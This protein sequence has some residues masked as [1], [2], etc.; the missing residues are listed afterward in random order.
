MIVIFL[1]RSGRTI[2]AVTATLARS[3]APVVTLSPSTSMSGV[4]LTVSPTSPST[5]FMTTTSPTD[6]F[7]CRPPALTIA[8][9]TLLLISVVTGPRA[10]SGTGAREAHKG[11]RP[12]RTDA[13]GYAS[14]G[15]G[16]NVRG[17]RPPPEPCG[18]GH[19]GGAGRAACSCPEPY[20]HR[21]RA[22]PAIGT[23]RGT[24]IGTRTQHPRA[25]RAAPARATLAW[26][27]LLDHGPAENTAGS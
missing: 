15:A 7:S 19:I 27:A 22:A 12:I 1:P 6:T 5:L 2:S 18:I 13:Q 11:V 21:D 26:V 23:A 17:P 16:A 24:S 3:S 14:H 8:Y 25:P 20:R 10:A 9:T 4:R